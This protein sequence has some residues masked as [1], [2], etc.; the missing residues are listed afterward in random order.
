MIGQGLSR[1]LNFTDGLLGQGLNV[2]VLITTNEPLSAMHPAVIRP[3]R[4]LSEMEF[5]PLA[6]EAAN[7][8]LRVHGSNVT[9]AKPTPLAQLY[10]THSGKEGMDR[11][12][13]NASPV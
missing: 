12:V 3:G 9:V 13:W 10:A 2:I 1:L 6:V 11:N 4:C 5:G 7:R 8:W